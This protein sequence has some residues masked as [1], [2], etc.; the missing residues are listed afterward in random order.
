MRPPQRTTWTLPLSLL[1]CSTVWA[2][3]PMPGQAQQDTSA[4]TAPDSD[5]NV[6]DD[7]TAST[8]S[9]GAAGMSKEE[10]CAQ[11][12]AQG[13]QAVAAA[14]GCGGG[15]APAWAG[16]T[17]N[18]GQSVAPM[19]GTLPDNDNGF[20]ALSLSG[21][22]RWALHPR[23]ALLLRMAA[24]Y[25]V[26]TPDFDS[27]S[28]IR[29]TDANLT[30]QVNMGSIGGFNFSGGP[31]ISAPTSR[32]SIAANAYLGT[33]VVLNIIRPINFL[34]G[35]ALGVGGSYAHNWAG[36]NTREIRDNNDDP[37]TLTGPDAPIANEP[38]VV[39]GS[40]KPICATSAGA[41]APCPAGALAT[42]G[43][44]FR[45]GAFGQLGLTS[46]LS[47]NASYLYGFNLARPIEDTGL[48]IGG[49]TLVDEVQRRGGAT[50]WRRFGSLSY[51]AA[52]QAAPWLTASLSVSTSVCYNFGSGFQ[53]ATGG[54]AGG[55]KNLPFFNRNPLFNRHSTVGLTMSVPI[56]PLVKA[57]QAGPKETKTVARLS[58][59]GRARTN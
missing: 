58:R 31:R 55:S 43:D 54:C 12:M 59:E 40:R 8:S 29:P 49:E 26:T 24:F 52:Y 23:V 10:R 20:Y 44:A 2:V 17:V 6:S 42:V 56:E 13:Q 57:I 22:G 7:A 25:E 34:Q 53:D 16:T 51:G 41:S 37:V 3:C 27:T 48:V 1:V 39:G 33:G 19:T 11:L 9:A 5:A 28:R 18:F 36:T 4:D 32:E 50:R 21:L 14:E 45:V 15:S 46:K 35:L 38:V 30:V 47:I